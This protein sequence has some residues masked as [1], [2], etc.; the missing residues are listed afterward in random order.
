MDVRLA[1]ETDWPAIWPI[2]HAVVAAGETYSWSPETDEPTARELWMLPAPAEVFVA[3][4]SG[5]AGSG[6]GSGRVLGTALLQPN[7]PGLGDH[8]A[9]AGFMVDPAAQGRGVGRLLAEYLLARAREQGYLA[10]QFN[11]V[12]ATNTGAVKLWRSLGFDV[13]GTV[14][15]GFRHARHGLV[16]LLI[17]YRRLG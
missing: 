16:D 7:K 9:N 13:I 3:S 2:W 17:M 8:V 1:S 5:R 15:D 4:E 10:M 14:P 6:S 12:V 11:A